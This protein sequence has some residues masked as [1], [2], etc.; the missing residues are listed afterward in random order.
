MNELKCR[1]K[2]Y[3]GILIK[4]YGGVEH[5]GF[6]LGFERLVMYLTASN[7][8]DHSFPERLTCNFNF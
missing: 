8:R 6:G 5:A 4:K 1:M 7:I 3:G 2:A